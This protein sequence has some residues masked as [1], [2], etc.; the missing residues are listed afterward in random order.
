MSISR[1]YTCDWR[2]C[3]H[4][5]QTTGL[6]PP[7]FLTVDEDQGDP[8]HFCTWDCV[9]KYAA[10]KPPCETIPLAAAE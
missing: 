9:L 7:M 4:H 6:R 3:N 8:L 2:E 5:V 1:T 10:E